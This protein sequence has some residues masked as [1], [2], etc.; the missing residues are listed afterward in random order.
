MFLG[1]KNKFIEGYNKQVVPRAKDAVL[2]GMLK[3]RQE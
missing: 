3:D 2:A 1:S